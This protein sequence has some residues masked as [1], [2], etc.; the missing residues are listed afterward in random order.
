[1]LAHVV[2]STLINY[3]SDIGI[4]SKGAQSALQPLAVQHLSEGS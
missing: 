3:I 2:I 4:S 1:M